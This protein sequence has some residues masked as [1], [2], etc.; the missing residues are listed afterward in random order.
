MLPDFSSRAAKV[1][2]WFG[3]MGI[4]WHRNGRKI[5]R[6]VSTIVPCLA[7]EAFPFLNDLFAA[8]LDDLRDILQSAF[9]D[10]GIVVIEITLARPG[11]P[12]LCGVGVGRALTDVDMKLMRASTTMCVP[13]A[14]QRTRAKPTAMTM[15]RI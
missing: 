6:K 9:R 13:S 11:D 4:F 12:N 10:A 7:K 2:C 3:A 15:L 14:G 8:G 5:P 1:G